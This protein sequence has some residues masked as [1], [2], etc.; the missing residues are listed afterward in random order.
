MV[1]SGYLKITNEWN[2][3]GISIAISWD[4]GCNDD[5]GRFHHDLTTTETHRWLWKEGD[6]SPFVALIQVSEILKFAQMV[7]SG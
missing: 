3:N 5:L 6:S 2:M 1:A 4:N 7:A